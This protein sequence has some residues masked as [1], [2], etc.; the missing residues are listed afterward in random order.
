MTLPNSA[1]AICLA[2]VISVALAAP[3]FAAPAGDEYL[4]KVPKASGNSAAQSSG[5]G[6][7]SSGTGSAAS[8]PPSSGGPAAGGSANAD[9][10]QGKKGADAGLAPIGGEPA[11]SPSEDSSDSTLLSPVAILLIAGVIIAAV[12]MTLRRRNADSQ[13]DDDDQDG[14]GPGA[15]GS[16]RPEPGKTAPTPDGEIVAGGDRTK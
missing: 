3:A 16:G 7:S 5:A 14:D 4:P 6:V 8:Q 9:A 10:K 1:R 2:A 11:S 13:D 12:G 15:A